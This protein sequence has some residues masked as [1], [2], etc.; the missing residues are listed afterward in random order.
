MRLLL[1]HGYT[2]R[3]VDEGRVTIGEA[4]LLDENLKK[5]SEDLQFAEGR[6]FQ[7]WEL[8]ESRGKNHLKTDKQRYMDG[9]RI[10][11]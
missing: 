5:M 3:D 2:Q 7:H 4:M 8:E 9:E 1:E 10:V 6:V 11:D